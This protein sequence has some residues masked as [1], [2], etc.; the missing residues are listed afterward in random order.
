MRADRR[1]FMTTLPGRFPRPLTIA[2]YERLP[3]D[4]DTWRELQEGC[5]VMMP[6]RFP[7]PASADGELRSQLKPQ[8]P[9][10][11]VLLSNID[12]NLELVP[13]EAPGRVRRPNLIVIDRTAYDRANRED[14]LLRASEVR[15]VAEIVS[16]G[17][18]RMDHVVKRG[19]YAEA[20][21]PYYWII[22]LR[23]VVSLIECRLTDDGSYQDNGNF[24]GEFVTSAPFPVR[25]DLDGLDTLST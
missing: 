23:P 8:L 15:L 6:P 21:I 3:E 11:V 5:L 12:V 4:A 16:R 7:L 13:P 1:N 20:G 19:E 25:I 2:D 17:S 14:A 24:T 9:G 22:D 18:V 10:D